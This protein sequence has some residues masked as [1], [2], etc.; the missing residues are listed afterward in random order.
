MNKTFVDLALAVYIQ[1]RFF[2]N[3]F[4]SKFVVLISHEQNLSEN[5]TK[6]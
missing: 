5:M 2:P 6:F 1:I 4:I 3:S